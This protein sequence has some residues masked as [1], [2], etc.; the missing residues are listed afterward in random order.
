MN[1]LYFGEVSVDKIV[2]GIE[3]FP[4]LNAFPAIDPTIPNGFKDYF[5]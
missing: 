5:C 3:R 4:A 1:T 2:D